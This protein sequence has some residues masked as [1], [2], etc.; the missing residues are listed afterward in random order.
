MTAQRERARAL[1]VEEESRRPGEICQRLRIPEELDCLVGHF[2]GLP[3]L[4]GLAQLDWAVSAA[5]AL[6][7]GPVR[8]VG[9]E[10]L[11]FRRLLRPGES[12][13]AHAR[14]AGGGARI[15][16]EMR[17][18]GT[19]EGIAASGRLRLAGEGPVAG[20]GRPFEATAQDLP[21]SDLVPH[22]P[23]MVFLDRLLAT[24]EQRTVCSLR[25]DR[26]EL[27]RDARGR[28]PGWAGIEPMAQCIAAHG[29]LDARRRGEAPRVGFLLG[30]RRLMVATEWLEPT[31]VYV[32][33]A[34]QVWGGEQGLV[35]F[36]CE[37]TAREG[38]KQLLAGRINAYLP[39]N[40]DEA[41]DPVL[42]PG[43]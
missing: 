23:P 8:V 17:T 26:L 33:S 6:R 9:V 32:T 15:E 3:I 27:F 34:V 7:E 43:P 21:V 18:A 39:E 16:F 2:P 36:D 10:A 20:T 42:D 12:F 37:L 35:S 29:G 25:V 1:E 5:E 14:E 13:Q 28:L 19:G 4:P 38:G 40:L 41:L 22:A 24:D 30:C 31:Q 11:K